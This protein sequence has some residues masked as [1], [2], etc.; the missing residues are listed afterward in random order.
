MIK[1]S[2]KA[3]KFKTVSFNTLDKILEFNNILFEF[4]VNYYISII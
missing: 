1:C 2:R 3:Q 4:C